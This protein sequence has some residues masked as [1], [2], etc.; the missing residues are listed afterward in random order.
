MSTCL[1]SSDKGFPF[2]SGRGDKAREAIS[3]SPPTGIRGLS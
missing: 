1:E 2:V 3:N